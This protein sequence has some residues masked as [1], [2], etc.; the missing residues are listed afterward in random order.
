[1][2][3]QVRI[4]DGHH[5]ICKSCELDELN[6]TTSFLVCGCLYLGVRKY[7]VQKLGCHVQD[8]HNDLMY[9]L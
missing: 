1:M 8:G 2:G 9:K 4:Q 5:Y 6:R 7:L 3:C